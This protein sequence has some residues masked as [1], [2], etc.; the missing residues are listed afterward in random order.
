MVFLFVALAALLLRPAINQ[1]K[2]ALSSEKPEGKREE[3]DYLLLALL[4]SLIFAGLL[5]SYLFDRR[6]TSLSLILCKIGALAFGGGFTAIP[7]IQYEIVDRLHW[8]TT[9]EFLDGILLG[10]VTPGPIL[11]TSTFLGYKVSG[12]LGAFMATLGVFFP[13]FFILLLLIPYHDRLRQM[14]IV[15]VIEQGI[16]ASFIGM[17]GFVLYNFGRAALVDIPSVIFMAAAFFALQRKIGLPYILF[18]GGIVSTLLYT[19]T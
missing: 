15:R 13:S 19:L 12:L 8:L 18:G 17:L 5:M 11:I 2:A 16:L 1:P 4:A 7:F 14:K 10:Q 9:K 6:L 3:N